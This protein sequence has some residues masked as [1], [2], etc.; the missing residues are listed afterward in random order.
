MLANVIRVEDS[1]FCRLTHA[2]AVR[3]DVS[4]RSHEDAEISAER[5]DSADGVRTHLLER[6]PAAF[7]FHE[8]WDWAE[9]RKNF[10]HCDRTRTRA[11]ATV[12]RRES[13]VQVQVHHIN[14][15]IAGTGDAGQRV[16]VR[17]VHVK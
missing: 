8:D 11:A 14:A 6:K 13:F 3:E 9:R 12:W 2:R 16:H 5:F 17:A 15:E 1:V 4:Q 10:F 7:F